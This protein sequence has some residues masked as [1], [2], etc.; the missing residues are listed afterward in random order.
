[1]VDGLSK[2]LEG[3]AV[4]VI[5]KGLLVDLMAH[6]SG[7]DVYWYVGVFKLSGKAFA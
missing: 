6:K 2:P 7:A 5:A 1:M 3:Q 4:G